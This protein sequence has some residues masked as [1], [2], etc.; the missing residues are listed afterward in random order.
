MKQRFPET[1]GHI[2]NRVGIKIITIYDRRKNH[3]RMY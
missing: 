1:V 2:P 3:T